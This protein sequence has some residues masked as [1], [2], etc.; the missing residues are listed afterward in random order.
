M[1]RPRLVGSLAPLLERG[2][3]VT[4]RD[5]AVRADN[6]NARIGTIAVEKFMFLREYFV[7]TLDIGRG[8][9]LGR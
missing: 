8:G 1:C 7:P 5:G 4:R 2:R 6:D 3:A 9:F